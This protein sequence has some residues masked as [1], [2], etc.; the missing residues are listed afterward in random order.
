T[1]NWLQD[2]N[3]QSI[4][5]QNEELRQLQRFTLRVTIADSEMADLSMTKGASK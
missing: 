3:M 5:A 2:P 4:I 1:S